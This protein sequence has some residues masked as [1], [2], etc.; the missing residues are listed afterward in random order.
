MKS[1]QTSQQRRG[2]ISKCDYVTET[3]KILKSELVASKPA[4]QETSWAIAGIVVSLSFALLKISY[5]VITETAKAGDGSALEDIKSI[6]K[7][8][9]DFI[10]TMI[11]DQNS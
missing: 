6:Q 2:I 11:A 1:L 5:E 8:F 4:E 10:E 9:N 3:L 7:Q